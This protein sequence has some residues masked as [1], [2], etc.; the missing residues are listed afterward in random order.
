MVSNA[1]DNIKRFVL[2]GEP[3]GE[4]RLDQNVLVVEEKHRCGG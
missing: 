4:N 2:P 3:L 1:R